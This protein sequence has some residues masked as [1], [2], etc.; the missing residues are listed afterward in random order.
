MTRR[1]KRAILSNTRTVASGFDFTKQMRALC[2]DI[3]RRLPEISHV[4]MNRVT[5]AFAQ[6]RKRV[7]HG[8]W[9]SLTPMRFKDGAL[10]EQRGRTTYTVERLF[11]PDGTEMLYILTFYLPR[12]TQLS[13]QDKLVTI[14]HELWHIS[15]QFDGDIR[16]HPGRCYAHT[17][18]E[19]EYDVAMSAL[20]QKWL[21]LGPPP[22]LSDFLRLS[23]RRLQ[24]EF[25]FVYGTKVPHP[26]LIPLDAA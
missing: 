7:R 6:T 3:T 16:R 2:V 22:E 11:G 8:M 1:A 9:A 20:A 5:V 26:K 4:D 23:F 24:E 21:S 13:F 19:K 15:P 12:F 10:A 25:G 17:Q 14:F 18:S